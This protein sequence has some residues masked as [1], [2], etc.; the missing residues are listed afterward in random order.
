MDGGGDVLCVWSF[1][2]VSAGVGKS[3]MVWNCVNGEGCEYVTSISD[4]FY[5]SCVRIVCCSR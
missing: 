2:I 4:Y 5:I 1:M 3:S